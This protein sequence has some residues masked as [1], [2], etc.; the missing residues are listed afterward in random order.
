MSAIDIEDVYEYS[1]PIRLPQMCFQTL[2]FPEQAVPSSL[3]KH[4]LNKMGILIVS[5]G[6][7][8]DSPKT[9][10]KIVTLLGE[11]HTHSTGD[12]AVWHIKQGGS[13]GNEALARS[14]KLS[15]FVLHTD[16][17]YE[18]QVPDFFALHC[19]RHDRLGGGKNLL[20]DCSTL[21]QHLT[22]E[23][24]EALQN[25]PVEIIVPPEFKRD[26]ESINARVIDQ[27]FNVRYRK[28]ILKSEV[29]T[30][31]LQSALEEFERLCH[32]PVL[33]RKLELKDNQILLLD[34]KRYLHARTT[35][36]DKD[37]HLMRIRFFTDFNKF[38]N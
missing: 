38:S 8:E 36:K 4:V 30:P 34:N 17:S 33:N 28:E 20:V 9:L 23:S 18:K 29:L 12:D 10:E 35:I 24:F 25:D 6:Y 7:E 14:H 1:Q 21:I 3:Y 16:C 22:P 15:E 37:R 13:R 11:A 32:S 2:D 19:I 5:L 27:N 31:A 26:I